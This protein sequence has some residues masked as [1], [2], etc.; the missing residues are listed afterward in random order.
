MSFKKIVEKLQNEPENEGFLVLVR[1]GVFFTGI[2]KDAII[3]T[4]KFG[5]TNICFTDGICKSSIPVNR[6]DK[7]LQKI[8]SQNVS[9]AI[10]EYNPK[11]LDKDKSEKYELL[12]R[13]VMSPVYET[14]KCLEC[15]KCIYYDSRIK[16]NIASTEEILQGIDNVLEEKCKITNLKNN[17]SEDS[18][19][20]R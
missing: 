8:I 13:I 2:G 1:C 16:T 10:Y 4:E 19:N 6:V 14:R 5:I 20:G 7:M 15:K 17:E 9:V 11:G 12:R 18:S 3:L